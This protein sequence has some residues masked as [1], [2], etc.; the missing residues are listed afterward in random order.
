MTKTEFDTLL[1]KIRDIYPDFKV[2]EV[3]WWEHLK[4]YSYQDVYKNVLHHSGTN[5]PLYAD[6][7]KGLKKEE[8]KKDWLLKCPVCDKWLKYDGN[9]EEYDKHWRRCQKI[10]FIN[11]QSKELRGEE[12]DIERY[13]NMSDEELDRRYRK[14]M[15]NFTSSNSVSTSNLFNKL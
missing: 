13:R 5:A 3:E 1:K 10:D 8:K 6:L 2:D 9:W 7:K 12:I 15:D 11:N 14:I 4:E